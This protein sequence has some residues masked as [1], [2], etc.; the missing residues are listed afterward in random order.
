MSDSFGRIIL[1]LVVLA[2]I[3]LGVTN[4]VLHHASGGVAKADATVR[5]AAT[6]RG[7]PASDVTCT[8]S[9][10]APASIGYVARLVPDPSS[11][12]LYECGSLASSTAGG[13]QQWC[14]VGTPGSNPWFAQVEDCS[15]WAQSGS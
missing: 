4:F 15:S 1:F 12:T 3:W 9:H 14:V 7:L 11:V 6:A 5:Q 2:G 8:K 13:E 10:I